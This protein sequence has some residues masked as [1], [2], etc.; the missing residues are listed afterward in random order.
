M[1]EPADAR[2]HL[3]SADGKLYAVTVVA[4]AYL[5]AWYGVSAF[6]R[7]AAGAAPD[8]PR[9]VWRAVWI[10]RLPNAEQPTARPPAGWR[11]ASRDEQR[12]APP[13]ERAPASRPLRARTRSS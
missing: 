11:V 4:V 5:I 7:P 13:I 8:A 3:A 6:P 10:D 2:R 9:A 12:A 1:T